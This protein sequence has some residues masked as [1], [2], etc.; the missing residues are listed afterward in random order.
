MDVAEKEKVDI[1]GLSGLITP[2]LD[3]MVY[4]AK[5]MER[6]KMNLPL[7]IGGATTSRIHTAV[8]I[9][10]AYSGP[11]VHV[12]DASKGVPAASSLISRK[13]KGIGQAVEKYKQEYLQLR[14]EHDRRKGDKKFLSLEESRQRRTNI[15]WAKHDV[16]RP[17][18]LGVKTLNSVPLDLLR[19]YIDW[20]PFFSAWELKG[21]YPKILSD[22]TVGT[23][24]T[25]LFN[26]AKKLLER[27]IRE[28]LFTAK[29]VF[30][31]FPANATNSDDVVVY[32]F[33]APNN[34]S[35]DFEITENRER[36]KAIL[37]FLRQQNKKAA[38]LPNI[39]LSDFIA[40][41]ES[42]KSDYIGAFVVTAGFGAPELAK[43]YEDDLDDYNSI[44]VKALADRLAEALAEYI[45]EKVRRDYWGY[46][47]GESLRNE[48][49]IQEKYRGIRPAPGY[50]A[51]PDHL[52]KLTLFHLLDAE[53]NIGVRL[54]ENLAMTPAASV[55]G[56]YF[57]HPEAK[58][59]GVGKIAKDQVVDYAMRKGLKVEEV[60]KWLAPVLA[61]DV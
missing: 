13:D 44:M 20:T 30:G 1:I 35:G 24:A 19:D 53:N 3:E 8:K 59:F 27:I 5:E 18:F 10:T 9:D 39:C 4:V 60:E 32:E 12:L 51:C 46:A 29:A 57:S 17:G 41:V 49:L 43:K 54:T 47:D 22:P 33:K 15:D 40:P 36:Q 14:L 25:Q 58:Y 16:V 38:N 7:L 26:D 50:P 6:R 48:E 31:I 56:W 42:G 34:E 52:E 45:H 11:V 55:S 37:H 61:Y 28:Q 23:E 2:S 21:R